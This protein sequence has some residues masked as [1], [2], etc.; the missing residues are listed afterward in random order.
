MSATG[1]EHLQD[2]SGKTHKRDSR[3][4]ECGAPGRLSPAQAAVVAWLVSTPEGLTHA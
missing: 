1:L 2:S 3:G 4:A